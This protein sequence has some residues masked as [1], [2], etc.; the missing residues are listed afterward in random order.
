MAAPNL[1]PAPRLTLLE[2]VQEVD[3]IQETLAALDDEGIDDETREQ[4]G[5]RLIEATFGTKEK[6]DR[7]AAKLA[8]F[9]AAIAAVDVEM[10]RLKARKEFF[11]RQGR[12]LEGYV[13]SVM[14]NSGHKRIDGFT[15]GLQWQLNPAK[16]EISE[17]T[18]F[19]AS[20]MRTPKVPDPEPDKEAI[21]KAMKAGVHFEGCK[22]IQ[23]PRLERV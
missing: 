6:I 20:F 23:H 21:K 8:E 19:D 1:I 10:K 18:K 13:L 11:E 15:S 3:L 22:L 9:E 2:R 14:V 16:L 17:G 5:A 4:L 12:R 7:T